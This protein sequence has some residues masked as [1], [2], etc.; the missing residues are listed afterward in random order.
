[1]EVLAKAS[2]KAERTDK[3]FVFS[4]LCLCPITSDNF[5]LYPTSFYFHF[6]TPSIDI[7]QS[8]APCKGRSVKV[9]NAFALTGRYV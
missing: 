2:G 5:W 8:A 7:S 9:Y 6:D 1:M 3:C 4:N